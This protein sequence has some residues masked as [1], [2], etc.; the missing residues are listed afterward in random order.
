MISLNRRTAGAA[1]LAAIALALSACG[2]TD[3]EEASGGTAAPASQTC[4]DDTT[5]TSTGPVSMTDGIGRTVELDKPAERVAVLEWQQTEDLLTLC[6]TPVAAASIDGYAQYV[7]AE[8]LPDSVASAGERGEPDLD[9]LYASNPDLIVMEVYQADDEL[10]KKLEKRGVPVLATVGADASGQIENMKEV[11][12][13]IGQA[14]GRTERADAVLK[15]FDQHFAEAK[16]KL[17]AANVPATDFL[18]FD[19]WIE[20]G[21]VVI[22]PYGQGALFT[23]IGEAL[24]M[25]SAWTDEINSAYGSGGVDK[26][27]GLAQTDIEGL[28]PVGDATLFYANDGTADNY[29][30]ELE[31]SPIW[32]TLPAV[33]EGRAHA[34]PNSVWGAGGP[35]SNEQAID[36]YVNIL[37]A[38]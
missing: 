34:F 38:K 23:E 17:T 16:E 2:T 29:V 26:S 4:A 10:L 36:A 21:N 28:I 30:T 7:T 9:A 22:R 32:K 5:T 31:K 6:V 19:G 27:Y 1:T 8:T 20:S 15:D 35:K 14:T 12:S 3:V 11:F 13:M 37:T 25:T 33:K 24:G 18:F